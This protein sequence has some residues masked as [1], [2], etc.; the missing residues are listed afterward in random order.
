[1]RTKTINPIA[2]PN[3]IVE[4]LPRTY[5]GYRKEKRNH[6]SVIRGAFPS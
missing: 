2:K 6:P 1:M 5:P 4:G 3:P